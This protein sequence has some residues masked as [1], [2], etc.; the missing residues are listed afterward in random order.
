MLFLFL[1]WCFQLPLN[2]NRRPWKIFFR[3]AQPCLQ[4]H[5]LFLFVYCI[6]GT[7]CDH[8]WPKLPT[9]D[10]CIPLTIILGAFHEGARASCTVFP[11]TDERI[12]P[13]G[14]RARGIT[15]SYVA[16][17]SA[18]WSVWFAPTDATSA[19][20]A[21]VGWRGQLDTRYNAW[22]S[23]T[24]QGSYSFHETRISCRMESNAHLAAPTSLEV[25]PGAT[26]D[27]AGFERPPMGALMESKKVLRKIVRSELRAM[28]AEQRAEEGTWKVRGRYM[29]GTRKVWGRY[30]EQE[31][32]RYYHY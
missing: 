5:H 9:Q 4:T 11:L 18:N 8:P 31:L 22:K 15:S 14:E 1:R 12:L 21:E 26:A 3:A 29:E 13:R 20:I 28:S 24:I 23:D 17:I 30:I 2:S 7:F 25:P 10:N 6:F 19:R 27:V 16:H 32:G